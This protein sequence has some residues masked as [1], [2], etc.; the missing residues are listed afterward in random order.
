LSDSRPHDE[1]EPGHLTLAIG[2]INLYNPNNVS[3]RR[4]SVSLARLKANYDFAAR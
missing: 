1:K 3:L 4:P 2:L